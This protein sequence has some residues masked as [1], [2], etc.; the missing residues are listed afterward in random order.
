M[1]RAASAARPCRVAILAAL[2]WEVRPF[3][4]RQR[5]RP[6]RGLVLPSW[7]FAAGGAPGL[8][9]LT[10]MGPGAVRESAR[11]LVAQVHPEILVSLGFGGALTP[12]LPPG[13]LVLGGSVWHYDPGRCCLSPAPAP[14]PPR[15]L[16]E[17]L[18]A[19]QEAGCAAEAGSLVTTPVILRKQGMGAPVLSLTHP[20][21]DL[22]SAIVAGVAASEGLPFLGLRAITDGAGEEIP[23]FIVR[24]GGGVG[25]GAALSWLAADPRRIKTL[26][27]LWRHS[28]LAAAHLSRALEALLPLLAAS[29]EEL[30]GQPGQEG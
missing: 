28:Q 3:L 12:E 17:L 7:E 18:T 29:G 23:E 21:L 19:L 5:A 22:E 16:H 11:Q 27:R 6:R 8:V 30:Q 15:P 26:I 2:I 20:V 25:A 10:G 1:V 9:S 4:R 14:A 13:A 24:A